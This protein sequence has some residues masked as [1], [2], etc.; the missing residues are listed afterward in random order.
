MC[1]P[2]RVGKQI[3]S[4]HKKVDKLTTKRPLELLH[5]DLM[6][7]TKVVSIGGKKYIFLTVDDFSRLTWVRF[8]REESGTFSVFSDLWSLLIA[9]KVH[10]FGGV[11]CI[12]LDHGTEFENSDFNFF[13]T[14][15]G[16]N[17]EFFAQMTLHKME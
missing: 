6:G 10:E 9:N 8:L 15:H 12:C 2:C 3:R 16:I 17:H 13:C 14:Q 7:R 4:A 11:S 5:M 1:G